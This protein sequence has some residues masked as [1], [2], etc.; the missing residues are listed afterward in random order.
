MLP[1]TVLKIMKSHMMGTATNMPVA[2]HEHGMK[3]I[4]TARKKEWMV[5]QEELLV[6]CHHMNR[7]S[8]SPL[9]MTGKTK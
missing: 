1:T 7:G 8:F 4:N 6:F 5:T 2:A 3:G 9:Y